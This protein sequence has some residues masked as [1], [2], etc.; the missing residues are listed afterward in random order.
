VDPVRQAS[1]APRKLEQANRAQEVEEVN[2]RAQEPVEV[3]TLL[4]ASQVRLD[5]RFRP[6]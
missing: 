3:H 6:A 1:L 2:E 4:D 5:V